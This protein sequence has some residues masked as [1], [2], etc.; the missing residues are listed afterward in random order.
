MQSQ[1][2][3]GWTFTKRFF[4]FCSSLPL[5][6]L[7]FKIQIKFIVLKLCGQKFSKL[8]TFVNQATLYVNQ[9]KIMKYTE[10]QMSINF[11]VL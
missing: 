7:H 8:V 11:G 2:E 1:A 3:L 5:S 4:Y 6:L 10:Q 9:S